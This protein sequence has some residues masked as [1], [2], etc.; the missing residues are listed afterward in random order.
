MIHVILVAV[1]VLT[2]IIQFI[3]VNV[4]FEMFEKQLAQLAERIESL[5]NEQ[6]ELHQTLFPSEEEK[7]DVEE[8]ETV[9]EDVT[10]SE[11]KED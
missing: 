1:S 4:N 6:Y 11:L 9:K 10:V 3:H 8:D 7:E 2:L 5:E